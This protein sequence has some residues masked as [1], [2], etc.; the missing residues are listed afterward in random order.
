M[1]YIILML[2]MGSLLACKS[3]DPRLDKVD[4]VQ[5]P[6]PSWSG[7]MK[8]LQ[9]ILSEVEPFLFNTKEFND[10]SNQ[11]FIGKRIQLLAA[12]SKNI[13][14]NPTLVN[15]DPTV[16][17]VASQFSQNLYRANEAFKSGRVEYARYEVMKVTNAC[18]QCHTRMQQGPEFSFTR[19][20]SFL[21]K[22]PVLDQ[23]EFLIAS[24]NYNQA[25]ELLL[26]S[27]STDQRGSVQFWQ[28]DRMANLALQIAVQYEQSPDKALQVV[29]A[30]ESSKQ[31]PI[32]L[33]DRARE[34]KSEILGW[35]S[36]GQ[37]KVSLSTLQ[38]LVR[39]NKS[40]IAAM[41]AIP[42]LLSLLSSD[43]ASDEYGEALLLTGES[44][45]ILSHISHMALHENYYE[46][47][48]RNSPHTKT[49]RTCHKNLV[50]SVG[51][52]YSGSSGIHI[53]LN[54]EIWLDQLGKESEELNI[55]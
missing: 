35:K 31:I 33:R 10:P 28:L 24:R 55:K 8:N 47:C 41:R 1:K 13:S 54:I 18:I 27:L 16:R 51:L 30:I 17:F 4:A 46:S 37:K 36:E 38:Q 3:K 52:G 29:T 49:A 21:K 11:V 6:A 43:L 7:S 22:L 48:I 25:Y 5:T 9:K 50:R 26:K 20:E 19:N 53:P 40:E 23:A 15:R 12:E 45:E 32:S 39:K 2:A 14:H 44:Y 34:W 42:S